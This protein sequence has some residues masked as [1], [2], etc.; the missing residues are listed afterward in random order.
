MGFLKQRKTIGLVV[1]VCVSMTILFGCEALQEAQRHKQLRIREE[2]S[3]QVKPE[4]NTAEGNSLVGQTAPDF[5]LTDLNGGSITLSNLKGKAV[6]LN[7][8]ATW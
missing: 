1:T 7:F 8:W 2:M 3:N 4:K 5:T 6:L